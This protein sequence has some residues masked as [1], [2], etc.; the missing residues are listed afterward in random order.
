MVRDYE[1][2]GFRFIAVNG[3]DEN[4]VSE[5]SFLEMKKRAKAENYQFTY[6][7]DANQNFL[8]S[9][10]AEVTPEAFVF[11]GK[12]ECVYRGGIDDYWQDPHQ[13]RNQYLRRALTELSKMEPIPFERMTKSFGC[14][15]KWKS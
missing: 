10:G 1:P 4:Q 7:R 14:S 15:I 9:L 11:D 2:L 13:V 6:L 5:D 8:R 3:N 12:R